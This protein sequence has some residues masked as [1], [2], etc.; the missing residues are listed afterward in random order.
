MPLYQ[1]IIEIPGKRS[2]ILYPMVLYAVDMD[3]AFDIANKAW[4]AFGP[5]SRVKT[6]RELDGLP[7]IWQK[8][9]G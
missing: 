2:N 8:T 4:H 6:I 5:N 1:A 3:E 7:A 9:K